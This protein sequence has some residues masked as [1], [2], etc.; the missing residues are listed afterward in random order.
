[1]HYQRFR[2]RFSV[3][4]GPFT[5][6]VSMHPL[7]LVSIKRAMQVKTGGTVRQVAPST[8]RIASELFSGQRKFYRLLRAGCFGSIG[9]LGSNG[10]PGL[11][12]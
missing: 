2:R 3:V 8:T 6:V 10:V 1:M 4:S 9:R 11:A 7:N 12:F 5:A